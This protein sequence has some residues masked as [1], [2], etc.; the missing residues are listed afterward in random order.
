M[1]PFPIFLGETRWVHEGECKQE[2]ETRNIEIS[3]I[4]LLADNLAACEAKANEAVSESIT[5]NLSQSCSTCSNVG[6]GLTN[7]F[8]SKVER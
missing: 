2:V 6:W 8:F 3:G 4:C 1:F 5:E 7:L